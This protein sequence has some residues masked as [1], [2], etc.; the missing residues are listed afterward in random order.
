MQGGYFLI[1]S[2]PEAVYEM[3]VYCC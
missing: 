2:Q 1:I 3:R